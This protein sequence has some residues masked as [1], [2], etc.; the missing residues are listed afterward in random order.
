MGSVSTPLTLA[1]AHTEM[2]V[3]IS[4]RIINGLFMGM[5]SFKVWLWATLGCLFGYIGLS[6]GCIWILALLH[7]SS[8]PPSSLSFWVWDY[9]GP[10]KVFP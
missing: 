1:K 3:F 10:N 8:S 2:S 9:W 6:L 5:A 4:D 7:L